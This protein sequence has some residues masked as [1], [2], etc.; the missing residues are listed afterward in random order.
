MVV[1]RFCLLA[2]LVSVPALPAHA[3]CLE[4]GPAKVTLTGVIS[5][6]T[7]FGPPN[8]GEDPK[9]DSKER[10]LY[11]KLDKVVCVSA[12][13]GDN[14]NDAESGVTTMQMVYFTH[15][16]FRKEWIGK[17]VSVTG[18]LFHGFSGHH[19]TAVLIDAA[20]THI[21]PQSGM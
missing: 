1:W 3:N 6:R 18:T 10:H 9:R 7:D 20:E 13:A 12:Q 2:M 17:H 14:Y 15:L 8:Y 4:Y 21:L 11:L 19:W 5:E 16:K